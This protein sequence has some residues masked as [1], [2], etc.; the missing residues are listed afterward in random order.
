[1]PINAK[2]EFLDELERSIRAVTAFL[3]QNGR[4]RKRSFEILQ[5]DARH[6]VS[7]WPKNAVDVVITSPPYATALPYLDTDRLSLCY[8]GLLSRPAHRR[9]DLLM[10]GNREISERR[11]S[12]ARRRRD[13]RGG[14]ECHE[15]S[16][17]G[18][19]PG[20]SLVRFRG[21]YGPCLR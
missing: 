2:Q 20:N 15:P 19:G 10:I 8:L 3:Y 14:E 4:V 5:G 16:D 1:M 7:V 17:G 13:A 9:R 6:C 18:N 12:A 11:R 21:R